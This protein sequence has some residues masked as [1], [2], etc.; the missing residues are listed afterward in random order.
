MEIPWVESPLSSN[1]ML[2]ILLCPFAVAIQTPGQFSR[3]IAD[4]PSIEA[5]QALFSQ[6]NGPSCGHRFCRFL[7]SIIG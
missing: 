2:A 6:A 4:T 7:I 3:N 5:S 1:P